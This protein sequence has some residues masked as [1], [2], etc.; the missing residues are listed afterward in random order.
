[1]KGPTGIFSWQNIP[2]I[3]LSHT[4]YLLIHIYIHVHVCAHHEY[5]P[6]AQAQ[7]HSNIFSCSQSDH[8]EPFAPFW[9]FHHSS[10]NSYATPPE[11]PILTVAVGLQQ[12]CP[13]LIPLSTSAF[14]NEA[15]QLLL[16]RKVKYMSCSL[17]L[18]GM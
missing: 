13:Y 2:F 12:A 6:C 3:S 16:F 8:S 5:I 9:T 17:E 15:L 10:L 11:R 14:C 18:A 1:M 7:V 4:I